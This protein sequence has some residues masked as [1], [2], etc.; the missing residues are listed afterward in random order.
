MTIDTTFTARPPET[1][2]EASCSR[3]DQRPVHMLAV[4]S[5]VDLTNTFDQPF[6]DS[7]VERRGKEPN[8]GSDGPPGN[9]FLFDIFLKSII[10][11]KK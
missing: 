11:I 9:L 5:A 6:A 2:E 4:A 10:I 8:T 7:A 1:L 3:F